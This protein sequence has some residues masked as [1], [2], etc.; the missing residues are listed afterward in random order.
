MQWLKRIFGKPPP[1]PW[2]VPRQID[3]MHET[4][5]CRQLEARLTELRFFRLFM[6]TLYVD[7]QTGQHWQSQHVFHNHWG[8][9]IYEPRSPETA[10]RLLAL[11]DLNPHDAED[12]RAFQKAIYGN[13]DTG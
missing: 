5:A 11:P 9:D 10:A 3:G 7:E 6:N 2:I 13:D 12:A 8:Y 1:A 4:E